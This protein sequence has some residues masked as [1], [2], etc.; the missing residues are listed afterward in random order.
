MKRFPLLLI[1]DKIIYPLNIYQ[2]LEIFHYSYFYL[3][4][5]QLIYVHT[6]I[7]IQSQVEIS[8]IFIF[9]SKFN[10]HHT[11]CNRL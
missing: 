4:N 7:H 2:I 11:L 6:H 10:I 5:N 1:K 3:T 9:V 8:N